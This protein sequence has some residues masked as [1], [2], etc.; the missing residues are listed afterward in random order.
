MTLMQ[1]IG[2]ILAAK[3]AAIK[4]LITST[5]ESTLTDAKSYTDQKITDLVNSAPE[6]LD[7]LG[8]IAAMLETHE[9]ALSAIT[10]A[11]TE[12]DHA[13]ATQETH[14]FMSTADKAKL[15]NLGTYDEFVT[16][17]DA[18]V[19]SADNIFYE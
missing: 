16:A 10:S 11:V 6:T 19:G 1:Q 14:G 5:A 17:F 18:A 12:H 4:A 9:D 8:E 15:D 7:T 2:Q 3:F 13:D